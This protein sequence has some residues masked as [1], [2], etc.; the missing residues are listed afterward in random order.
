MSFN[1]FGAFYSTTAE[2]TFDATSEKHI[3]CFLKGNLVLKIPLEALAW[4]FELQE[5]HSRA[6]MGFERPKTLIFGLGPG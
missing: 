2:H 5:A 1:D 4:T 6:Q 3:H